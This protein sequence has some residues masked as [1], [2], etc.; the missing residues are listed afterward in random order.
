MEDISASIPDMIQDA[1]VAMRTRFETQ[2]AVEEANERKEQQW[3][4]A[5][6]RI[7]QEPPKEREEIAHDGRT[8]YEKV[9][10]AEDART[11]VWDEKMKLSNQY[12]GLNAE[13]YAFLS[14]RDKEKREKEKAVKEEEARELVGYREALAAKHLDPPTLPRLINPPSTSTPSTSTT[15]TTT[16]RFPPKAIKKDVRSLLKG[17]VVKKKSKMEPIGKGLGSALSKIPGTSTSSLVEER[18]K[19]SLENGSVLGKRSNDGSW[20]RAVERGSEKRGRESELG[21]MG[22]GEDG[23]IDRNQNEEDVGRNATKEVEE[24]GKSAESTGK[25]PRLMENKT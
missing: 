25:K 5:Y 1:R 2:E 10:A 23:G 24:G 17:V 14:D 8:L 11:A 3:K 15:T 18:G 20:S 13:E 9:K 16:P 4:E 7:G 22:G 21:Q 12:R 19:T 6:A